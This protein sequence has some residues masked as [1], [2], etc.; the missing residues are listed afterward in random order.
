MKLI[1]LCSSVKAQSYE[2][3]AAR[4]NALERNVKNGVLAK[5]PIVEGNASAKDMPK[6]K[7]KP[8]KK[9]VSGDLK[10]A[11]EAWNTIK[12]GFDTITKAMLSQVEPG[13]KDSDC[14]YLICNTKAVEDLVK[15]RLALICEAYEK[16]LEKSFEL[17]TITREEYD[18]WHKREFGDEAEE[19]SEFESL[20]S[21]YIPDAEYE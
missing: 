14:L 19:D 11:I 8:K 10:E 6:P 15:T 17:R 16:A 21:S 4:L 1:Q 9:A 18:S 3:L 7:P 5:A 12:A 2:A 20:I 13:V